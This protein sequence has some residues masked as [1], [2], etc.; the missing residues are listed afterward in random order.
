M[1]RLSLFQWVCIF[2]LAPYILWGIL[3]FAFYGKDF[4]EP[5]EPLDWL[6]AYRSVAVYLFCFAFI[7][8]FFCKA[9]YTIH[10]WDQKLQRWGRP[11]MGR[12]HEAKPNQ[13]G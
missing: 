8:Y 13:V 3:A 10:L 7:P 5:V 11:K 1:K 6:Q 12:G 2:T 4:G 9:I